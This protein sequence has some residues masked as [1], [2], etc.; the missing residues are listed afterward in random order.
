MRALLTAIGTSDDVLPI[1]ALGE[2]LR[3]RGHAVTLVT[4]EQF[5]VQAYR[6]GIGFAPLG[7]GQQYLD[8]LS[9]DVLLWDADQG[10]QKLALWATALVPE[11]Y[12]ILRAYVDTGAS[13]IVAH[14]LDLASRLLE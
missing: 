9:E 13:V 2:S 1:L 14:P 10:S 5:A 4:H 12:A 3:A 7:N 8:L 6:A 11:L